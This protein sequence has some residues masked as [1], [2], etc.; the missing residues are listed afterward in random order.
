MS[1]RM[2][3]QSREIHIAKLQ[4]LAQGAD[5]IFE[6]KQG[7]PTLSVRAG[8]GI[9]LFTCTEVPTALRSSTQCC[10]ELPVTEAG[11][12]LFMKSLTRCLTT[13]CTA[14][15][16]S[17]TLIAVFNLGTIKDPAWINIGQSGVQNM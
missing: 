15:T 10:Q 4:Q 7:R 17:S 5:H 13:Q 1:Y 8:E 12:D 6:D 16:C 2:C 9:Y 14:R 11:Q 3:Q